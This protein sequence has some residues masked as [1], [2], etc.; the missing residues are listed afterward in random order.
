[1]NG[2]YKSRKGYRDT[3]GDLLKFIRNIGEH[4]NEE[5]NR[6]MKEILGD[7]SRYF[8]ETFPDLVI[9]IYKKLKETEFRK[10]FPQPPPS[11]SVPEAAGP[12][13]VQS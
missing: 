5:K 4:I 6:Q 3:V 11:L 1:M 12:G 10:H 2:F 13:G 8:Q 7:P 9:Y